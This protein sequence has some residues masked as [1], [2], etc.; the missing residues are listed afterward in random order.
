MIGLI[1]IFP[2]VINP[3]VSFCCVN[4]RTVDKIIHSIRLPSGGIGVALLPP[5]PSGS[6]LE[7]ED[8][9]E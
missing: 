5:L 4:T 1:I 7:K 8:K 2:A 6:A 9:T 3:L